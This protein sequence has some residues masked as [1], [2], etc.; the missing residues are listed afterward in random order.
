MHG[1]DYSYYFTGALS[2]YVIGPVDTN[3]YIGSTCPAFSD[4]TRPAD[5]DRGFR[6]PSSKEETL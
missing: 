6:Q 1:F 5:A 3:R 4:N 2:R